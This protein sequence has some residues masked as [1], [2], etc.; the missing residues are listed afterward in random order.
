METEE[1][2]P[3]GFDGWVE[4][5]SK[6]T[7]RMRALEETGTR[8]VIEQIGT[9]LAQAHGELTRKEYRKLRLT[10]NL[11]SMSTARNYRRVCEK[12]ILWTDGIKEHLPTSIGARIDLAAWDDEEIDEAGDAGV[13]KPDATRKEL[14]DWRKL[15]NA[16]SAPPMVPEQEPQPEPESVPLFTVWGQ[17]SDWTPEELVKFNWRVEEIARGEFGRTVNAH[18]AVKEAEAT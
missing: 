15:R 14:R 18:E 3:L 17:A 4:R 6:F 2:T 8:D 5:I 13:I 1:P 9:A 16:R 10:L 7:A 12:R 11:G